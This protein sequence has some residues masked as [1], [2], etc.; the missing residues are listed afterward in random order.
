MW[1]DSDRATESHLT[2]LFLSPLEYFSAFNL[3]DWILQVET[4]L[5]WFS[6]T[7]VIDFLWPKSSAY[8]NTHLSEWKW[9][10][11]Y[12]QLNEKSVNQLQ[13]RQQYANQWTCDV[14]ISIG[15]YSTIAVVLTIHFSQW[16]Y[17][18]WTRGEWVHVFGYFA[19]GRHPWIYRPWVSFLVWWLGRCVSSRNPVSSAAV[20]SRNKGSVCSLHEK[21][22][23]P[24]WERPLPRAAVCPT[25]PDYLC[26]SNFPSSP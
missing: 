10:L 21:R 6:L 5:L 16:K 26:L 25:R 2:L 4:S 18:M 15:W 7:S 3:I 14:D 22:K 17:R 12:C 1:K 11:V 24:L 9:L 23:H 8:P 13:A 19:V 20:I